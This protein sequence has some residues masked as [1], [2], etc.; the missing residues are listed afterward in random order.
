[1]RVEDCLLVIG[2]ITMEKRMVEEQNNQLVAR[3]RELEKERAEIQ[4]E[5]TSTGKQGR[6]RKSRSI[7]PKR[8]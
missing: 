1:M 8:T 7:S 5:D 6:G 4:N 3:L 2:E